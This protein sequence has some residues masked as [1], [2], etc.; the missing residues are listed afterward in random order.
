M[1]QG[2]VDNLNNTIGIMETK[3]VIKNSQQT[4]V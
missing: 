3:F 4:E 1:I 2:K